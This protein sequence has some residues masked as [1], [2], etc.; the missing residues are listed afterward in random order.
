MG[1]EGGGRYDHP[2]SANTAST[3]IVISGLVISAHFTRMSTLTIAAIPSD[4]AG[5]EQKEGE[6]PRR[7]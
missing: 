5:R 1:G 3:E 6:E 2:I 7:G 4:E